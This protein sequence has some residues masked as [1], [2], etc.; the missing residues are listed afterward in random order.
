[1]KRDNIKKY[2]LLAQGITTRC[3]YRDVCFLGGAYYFT[4]CISYGEF[5]NP[6]CITIRDFDANSALLSNNLVRGGGLC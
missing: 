4:I 5:R 1:M 3:R 2:P 6:L